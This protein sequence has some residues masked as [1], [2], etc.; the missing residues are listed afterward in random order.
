MKKV[1]QK[2]LIVFLALSLIVAAILFLVPIRIFDGEIIWES[3]L[4]KM[5]IQE[6]F[7]LS[8][9]VG[10]GYNEG[11]MTH[12]KDFYLTTKG[13]IVACILIFGVPGLFAYRMYLSSG[14]SDDTNK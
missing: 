6:K 10:V 14:N 12:V 3:G 7:C 2:P 1:F 4:Q 11:N 8:D 9:F 13:I 5:V